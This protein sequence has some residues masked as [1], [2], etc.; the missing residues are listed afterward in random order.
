V[1]ATEDTR[2]ICVGPTGIG[3]YVVV[4][5]LPQRDAGE[6]A[7]L[8]GAMLMCDAPIVA[9]EVAKRYNVSLV[10]NNLGGSVESSLLR[11]HVLGLNIT[12]LEDPAPVR[13]VP[14][15][16]ILLERRTGSRTFVTTGYSPKHAHISQAISQI[17]EP[18]GRDRGGVFLYVDA[19]FSSPALPDT[20]SVLDSLGFEP[21]LTLVNLDDVSDLSAA[22][23]WITDQNTRLPV[24]FQMGFKG[25]ISD[26]SDLLSMWDCGHT[27][28]VTSGGDGA[29]LLSSGSVRH[30]QCDEV[31]DSL[32]VG[33]GAI[34]SG[35]LLSA[36]MAARL[37]VV[38]ES[39][40][41]AAVREA[42]CFVGDFSEGRYRRN[43][44]L[45]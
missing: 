6:W 26:G 2:L 20:I 43:V 11:K 41:D 3:Y 1:A 33:A 35:A 28:V 22:F 31:R 17:S 25:K 32:T 29:F 16:V 45:W 9:S 30:I 27:V 36:L 18:S 8:A 37:S 23:Q 24:V 7:S 15:D 42:S 44:F 5:R 10:T 40:L 13:G 39:A 34:L 12:L 14:F 21:T 19:E 38:T 4:D